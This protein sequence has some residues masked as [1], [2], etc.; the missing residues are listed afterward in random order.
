[1]MNYVSEWDGSILYVVNMETY[2]YLK[3]NIS[4]I[5]SK[6]IGLFLLLRYCYYFMLFLSHKD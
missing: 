6:L 3:V 4:S 2:R 1:M 5:N